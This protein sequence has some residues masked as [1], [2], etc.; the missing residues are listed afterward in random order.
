MDNN[1]FNV[2]QVDDAG[3]VHPKSA[4]DTV[5]EMK[6]FLHRAE[7]RGEEHPFQDVQISMERGM[8]MSLVDESLD[9]E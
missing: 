3:S 5:K 4:L 1:G 9:V 8:L 6:V 2:H 7:R